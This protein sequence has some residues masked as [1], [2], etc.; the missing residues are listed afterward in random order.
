MGRFLAPVLI[1]ALAACDNPSA[2]SAAKTRSM[3][4]S[5]CAEGIE[6]PGNIQKVSK[7]FRY[8]PANGS[9]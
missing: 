9:P 1:L 3:P 2:P 4:D 6:E 8:S 5:C 7:G